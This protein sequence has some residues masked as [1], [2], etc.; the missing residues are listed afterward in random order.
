MRKGRKMD[1]NNEQRQKSNGGRGGVKERRDAPMA[2]TSQQQS[3]RLTVKQTDRTPP[4][5]KNASMYQTH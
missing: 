3:E 4:K 1:K 2:T 5:V